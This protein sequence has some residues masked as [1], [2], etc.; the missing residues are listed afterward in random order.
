MRK[1]QITAVIWLL[2]YLPNR[3]SEDT[4]MTGSSVLFSIISVVL[5]HS[6][7]DQFQMD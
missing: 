5:K 6:A 4:Q 2:S 1:S 3:S 7:E